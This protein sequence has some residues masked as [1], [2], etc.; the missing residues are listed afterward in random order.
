MKLS[1]PQHNLKIYTKFDTGVK[2]HIIS[3]TIRYTGSEFTTDPVYVINFKEDCKWL[4]DLLIDTI[5]NKVKKVTYQNPTRR[6]LVK[7]D[8]Y[9]FK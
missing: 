1:I 7:Y 8:T 2:R 9:E 6:G 3:L 4:Y 5:E